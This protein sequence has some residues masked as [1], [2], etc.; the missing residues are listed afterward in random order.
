MLTEE[1]N[2]VSP[3]SNG[4]L[5]NI[6]KT[7]KKQGEGK[8]DCEEMDEKKETELEWKPEDCA[9][10]FGD[11]SKITGKGEK[12]KN[13]FQAFKFQGKQYGLDIYI[14]NKEKYVK[15]EVQWF[16]RPEDVDAKSIAKWKSNGARSLFYSFHRDEVH[17]ESVLQS[18]VVHFVPED[19][20]IP[21]RAGYPHD[22]IVQ[23]VYDFAKKKLRKLSDDDFDMHQKQEIDH[24]VTETASR[25][26]DLPAIDQEENQTTKITPKCL[27]PVRKRYVRKAK[28][29]S[30]L[31]YGLI[32]EGFG[33]L[34]GDS[35]RDKTL[36][37]LLKAVKGRCHARKK[38]EVGEF[39]FF[40]PD[41]VVPMVRALEQS[42]Y[43]SLA[44]DMPKYKEKLEILVTE[45]MY[46]RL[47]AGRLM[48]GELKLEQVMKMSQY[49]L[50]RLVV[51]L[52]DYETNNF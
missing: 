8:K 2:Q 47:L 37:E 11:V 19:K 25:F 32:L 10:P 14:P 12:E 30:P 43:D 42:L 34:T 28:R 27:G 29:T 9:Q 22:F 31:T 1:L 40:W 38:K 26:G 15:L 36:D 21:S 4:S 7:E 50:R 16:Y 24:L 45:F 13:H 33:L 39:D 44:Q 49:E 51:G 52:Y 3:R 48:D 23:N 6:E 20:Q 18:C 17:A 35:V 5:S 46:S 41:N